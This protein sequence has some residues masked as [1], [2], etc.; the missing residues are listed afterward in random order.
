MPAWMRWGSPGLVRAFEWLFV[1]VPVA[2]FCWAWGSAPINL[3][4]R[5]FPT[6][7]VEVESGWLYRSGQIRPNLV[8]GTLRNLDIDV[9]VDLTEDRGN[10]DPRQV[11][12]TRA[13]EKL[14]IEVRRFPMSGK[15]IGTV[16]QYAAA[17]G[18]IASARRE[19]RRVLVHCA[20]GD[21]RTGGVLAAYRLLV[22]GVP[23]AEAT[24]EL[25]RFSQDRG[26]ETTLVRF[27]R[28]H[29]D[30]IAQR[31]VETGV[32]ARLPDP[33]PTLASR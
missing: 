22:E 7:L 19:G 12:E 8:E 25:E 1:L 4:E 5:I 30:E 32:I 23:P 33:I 16:D 9:I 6:N 17:I 20:A 14:A 10:R 13:V 28:E 11:A 27:L 21:R 31:L 15:G 3:R 26:E 2:V 29:L 18:A 24:E